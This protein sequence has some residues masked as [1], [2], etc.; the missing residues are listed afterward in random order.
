MGTARWWVSLPPGSSGDLPVVVAL[1]G[2]GGSADGLLG[3]YH[4]DSALAASGHRFAIAAIDGGAEGFWHPR[5]DGRDPLHLLLEAFLPALKD[6]ALRPAGLIGWSMGGY[7]ALLADSLLPSKEKLPVCA[8]SPGILLRY[9][10]APEWAFDG[11]DDF[12]RW[13]LRK[14]WDLDPELVRVDCGTEDGLYPAVRRFA[15]EKGLSLNSAPGGHD[16][17]YWLPLVP[18]QLDWL[19]ERIG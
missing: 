14:R 10:D 16:L 7:G 8:V 11:P 3:A 4:L 13:D 12:R 19:A 1:H 15:E 18:S 9:A 17:D 6:Y 5:A 2:H